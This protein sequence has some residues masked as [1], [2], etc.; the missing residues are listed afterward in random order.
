MKRI[1]ITVERGRKTFIFGFKH[2]HVTL[3]LLPLSS[4]ISVALPALVFTS[5][6]L[7][8]QLLTRSILNSFTRSIPALY[9][10]IASRKCDL[11]TQESQKLFT[12]TS[13]TLGARSGVVFKAL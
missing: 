11:I 6:G 13:S 7:V 3:K 12:D 10:S 9:S 5:S 8:P 1:E 2:F 4:Y